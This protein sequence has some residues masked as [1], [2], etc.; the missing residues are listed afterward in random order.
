[1]LEFTSKERK[2]LYGMKTIDNTYLALIVFIVIVSCFIA[3][4]LSW[5]WIRTLFPRTLYYCSSCS[6]HL[7]LNIGT[8]RAESG[9]FQRLGMHLGEQRK[10]SFNGVN[11][12][13]K[14]WSR[15]PANMLPAS[16]H[17]SS[18]KM[19]PIL[20]G[21][22]PSS[23]ELFA[24]RDTRGTL[25]CG[26]RLSSRRVLIF[27][28]DSFHSGQFKDTTGSQQSAKRK[29]G[30][31][32][33]NVHKVPK[34]K[35]DENRMPGKFKKVR[36]SISDRTKSGKLIGKKHE[37]DG[38]TSQSEDEGLLLESRR[39]KHNSSAQMR[40]GEGVINNKR[41]SFDNPCFAHT[42][43]EGQNKP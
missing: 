39:K 17:F 19:S 2:Y 5:M 8:G 3:T 15:S 25:T 38:I 16:E 29:N 35:E 30:E 40:Q 14:S 27:P 20:P 43:E 10:S 4:F 12:N 37:A 22:S 23:A 9:T 11:M 26:N 6:H 7:G 1:L 21:A 13:I 36:R 18:S 41:S 24:R 33:G 31:S 32:N 28:S 34:D 42:E